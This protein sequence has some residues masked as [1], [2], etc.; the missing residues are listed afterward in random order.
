[1][2]SPTTMAENTM[3]DDY[4][5]ENEYDEDEPDFGAFTEADCGRWINGKLQPVGMCLL[6]GTEECDWD[7]P[8]R[9]TDEEQQ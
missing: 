2:V 1:M 5:Y 9:I 6:A 8:L 4:D 7:C 3:T